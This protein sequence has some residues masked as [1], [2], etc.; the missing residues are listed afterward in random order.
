MPDGTSRFS[1]LDGKTIYHFMGCR[2]VASGNQHEAGGAWDHKTGF[3]FTYPPPPP[4]PFSS[5]SALCSVTLVRSSHFT[6]AFLPSLPPSAC[7]AMHPS[8][9]AEYTVVAEISCAKVSEKAPLDKVRAFVT[10][11]AIDVEIYI[12]C[13]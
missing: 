12:I 13:I 8:T 11:T 6:P 3:H 4:F 1:T 5:L 7:N 2:C 9:F 10:S